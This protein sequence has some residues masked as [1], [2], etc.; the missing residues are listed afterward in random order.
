LS[1]AKW[2]PPSAK[3]ADYDARV[4]QQIRGANDSSVV[5]LKFKVRRLSANRESALNDSLRLELSDNSGV[6]G[7]RFCGD[8]FGN[9]LF[10][11]SEL[12]AQGASGGTRN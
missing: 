7:L 9:E 6:N 2:T 5:I 1:H 3:K 8:V 12:V 11:F 10:P 4:G